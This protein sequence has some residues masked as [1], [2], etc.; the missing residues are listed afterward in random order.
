MSRQKN[1]L[2]ATFWQGATPPQ[3]PNPAPTIHSPHK[4]GG[5]LLTGDKIMGAIVTPATTSDDIQRCRRAGDG[6]KALPLIGL[7]S[8]CCADFEGASCFISVECSLELLMMKSVFQT[9]PLV[10]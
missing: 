4:N 5:H 3:Y 9:I 6:T 2:G 8:P 7:G 1:A 10:L